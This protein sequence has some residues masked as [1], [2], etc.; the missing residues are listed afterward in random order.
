MRKV[1]AVAATAVF[2]MGCFSDPADPKTW[3]KKLDDPRESKEAVRQL[4]KLK[5]PKAV[6]PLITLYKR[7]RD[8][9][10][11]KA[12][13]SFKDPST[14]PV[15]IDSLD[16]SEDSFDNAS[17]AA[18]ALGDIGDKSAV[19]PLMKALVKPLPVKTRAN[20]VKLESMK[21]LNKLKD[22]KAVEALITVLSTSSEQQDF[23]LNQKAA[24]YLGTFADARAVPALVRGLFM[25][26]SGATAGANIFQQSRTSLIAIG[27]PAVD[28]LVET[29]QR[30]NEI[31]EADAKKNDFFP[32]IVTQKAT[33]LLG[34]I[35]S[36]KAVPA[37]IE[38]LG[39]VDEGLKAGPGKGVSGH[40]SLIVSLGQIGSADVVKPLL[41]ILS[42][43]KRATKHKS[44]AAEA[45]NLAGDVSAL[46]ALLKV[47]QVKFINEA[48]KVIDP[49]AGAVV[50]AAATAYSRLA[51][52]EG[53]S[54][55]FPKLPADLDESDVGVVF[56]N[57]AIRLALAKECKQ[58]VACYGKYLTDKDG[59]KAEKASVMLSRLGK[60]GLVELAKA[61]SAQ[62]LSVRLT[63]LAGMG[64][65]GDKSCTE[66]LD[67]L[68]K[69]IAKDEGKT[70]DTKHI[71]DEMKA[72]RAQLSH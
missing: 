4:V 43:P 45:L 59:I 68:A 57:A 52:E 69:Q 26:G 22:P 37:M 23:F 9:E 55:A 6:E 44:A 62:D 40:Q 12:I 15:L 34:D 56:K 11:L 39:K 2:C 60:P 61:V 63:V 7:S 46:P 47:A 41:G 17:V 33:M 72:V 13:A 36:P 1:L 24:I 18:T 53:A 54:A 16:Y 29:M 65:F 3:I 30:K 31:V 51:G 64:R 71:C 10:H 66:C 35:R 70:G 8:V 32:G 19:E 25:S 48:T 38:E 42:D 27:E 50:A 14:V 58:D 28:K 21:A 5:D 20:V 67:A 49:E